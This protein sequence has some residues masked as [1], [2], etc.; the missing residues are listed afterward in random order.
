MT[1]LADQLKVVQAQFEAAR[2][3]AETIANQE[4]EA[5][6]SDESWMQWTR[7]KK[8]ADMDVA[9]LEGEIA[10]LV[11]AIEDE[12]A[13]KAHEAN[14]I[15]YRQAKARYDELKA[16]VIRLR[17]EIWPEIRDLLIGLAEF[18]AERDQ[19]NRLPNVPGIGSPD[20][21]IRDISSKQQ[22]TIED[23]VV[24]VWCYPGTYN[25]YGDQDAVQ[26]DGTVGTHGGRKAFRLQRRQMRR[27]TSYAFQ[28]AIDAQPL[29]RSL[30]MPRLDYPYGDYDHQ[31]DGRHVYMPSDALA[32]LRFDRRPQPRNVEVIFKPADQPTGA[33]WDTG[34][35]V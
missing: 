8:L 1:K 15:A 26:L 35:A 18:E 12:T 20:K 29:W 34:P 4:A 31:F 32:Q 27:I 19:I 14:M 9:R 33:A 22:E 11:V 17:D 13:A 5:L 16:G 2:D 28:P 25:Q 23:I 24:D 30:V 21:N 6:A 10:R 3:A 7:R